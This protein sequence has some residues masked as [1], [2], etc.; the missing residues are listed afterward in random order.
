MPLFHLCFPLFSLGFH[1]IGLFLHLG[2]EPFGSEVLTLAAA[3]QADQEGNDDNST[4]HCQRDYQYLE[5]HPAEPPTCIIQWTERMRWKDGAHWICYTRL[6]F[7]TPQAR[8]VFQ[9]FL[10]VCPILRL[11]RLTRCGSLG[12]NCRQTEDKKQRS[13]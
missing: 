4:Y 1:G 8:H 13:D 2:L 9:T 6:S 10:T 3:E 5:V 12:E 7:D 11:T